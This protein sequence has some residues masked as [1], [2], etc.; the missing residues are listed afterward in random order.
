[1]DKRSVVKKETN[2]THFRNKVTACYANLPQLKG[3]QGE[4]YLRNRGIHVL[5][6]DNV[7]YCLEQ[8]VK[9]GTLQA[10]WSLATDSK[11]QLCY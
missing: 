6:A 11:G 5:P 2:V 7:R 1:S 3:T 4:A 9:N 10:L 8:P